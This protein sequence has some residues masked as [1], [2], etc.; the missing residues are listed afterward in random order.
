[1]KASIF[2]RIYPLVAYILI[3]TLLIILEDRFERFL[4]LLLLLIPLVDRKWLLSVSLWP[5][6]QCSILYISCISLVVL[7][8]LF[9]PDS[10]DYYIVML[11]VVALPEEWFFRAYLLGKLGSNRKANITVSFAFCFLHILTQGFVIG[12]MIFVPSYF[13]GW[14]YLKTRDIIL[15]IIMHSLFNLCFLLFIKDWLLRQSVFID[16]IF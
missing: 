4:Y 16:H 12:A 5:N 11:L 2:D 14:L 13:F 6:R 15:I 1:M 8:L 3:L 7:L 9:Y 10:V